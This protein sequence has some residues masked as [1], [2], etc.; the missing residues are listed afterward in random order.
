M[1]SDLRTLER[2]PSH[3][4]RRALAIV[5]LAVALLG[6]V[7]AWLGTTGSTALSVSVAP[8]A[9]ANGIFA[10]VDT[11]VTSNGIY[12]A[13][14]GPGVQGGVVLAKVLTA[15]ANTN[16]V[17]V[18]YAWTNAQQAQLI[19]TS[20][21]VWLSIGLYHT[22]HTGICNHT[23]GALDTVQP[24]VNL[25]E[26]GQ[27]YCA[28]LDTA[29]T[30]YPT[31]QMVSNKLRLS[32]NLVGGFLTPQLDGTTGTN[33]VCGAASSGA[34]S[35]DDAAWCNPATVSDNDQRALFAIAT[36]TT[37]GGIPYGSYQAQTSNLQVYM[38]ARRAS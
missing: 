9:P 1:Q 19:F 15:K 23:A 25:T 32:Q 20:S 30:G 10:T 12:R 35:A 16:R 28:V 17:Q 33:A 8:G 29:E 24:Y 27:G 18:S 38:Q 3:K 36:I 26:G 2:P 4:R 37:S 21:A 22:T 5:A 13:A 7:G 34:L 31:S 11:N 14:I 6:S